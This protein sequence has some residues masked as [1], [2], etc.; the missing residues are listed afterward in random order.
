MHFVALLIHSSWLANSLLACT[1]QGSYR[2]WASKLSQCFSKP[3]KCIPVPMQTVYT[4]THPLPSG[5]S[6]MLWGGDR[7]FYERP[8]GDCLSQPQGLRDRWFLL[9]DHTQR[10]WQWSNHTFFPAEVW[11]AMLCICHKKPRHWLVYT[12][13]SVDWRLAGCY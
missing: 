10:Q 5:R 13:K 11:I 12:T 2:K 6:L 7:D 9:P 4:H 8:V 3:E 1:H